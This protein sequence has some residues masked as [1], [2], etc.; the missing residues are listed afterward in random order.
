MIEKPS[1]VIWK[2]NQAA[3]IYIGLEV[4]KFARGPN[5]PADYMMRKCAIHG[6]NLSLYSKRLNKHLK[7]RNG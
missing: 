5:L 3:N 1:R 6:A 7:P 4:S 2:M